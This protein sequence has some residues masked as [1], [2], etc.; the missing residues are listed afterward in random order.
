M[1]LRSRDRGETWELAEPTSLDNVNAGLDAVKASD[2]KVYLVLNGG[3][4]GWGPRYKLDL[5]VSDDDGESWRLVKNLVRDER[6]DASGRFRQNPDRWTEFAYPAVLE[7]RPGVLG[8]SYTWNR[9]R[10]AYLELSVGH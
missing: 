3:S 2:G 1:E 9:W 5:V 4:E 10:I 8:I 7:V 6:R